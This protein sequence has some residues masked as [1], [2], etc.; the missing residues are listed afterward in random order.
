[1]RVTILARSFL[2]ALALSWVAHLPTRA[3]ETKN[4]NI[5]T[6]VQG[7]C[8]IRGVDDIRFGALDPSQAAN[9]IASGSIVLACT[10]G[11][12]FRVTI[13]QGL[14]ADSR[15]ATRRRLRSAGSYF[16]PYALKT[17]SL[18]GVGQGVRSPT[19]IVLEAV[20]AG[21]DFRDL[22]ADT[23]SDTLRVTVEY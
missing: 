17:E 22:P 4:V 11:V 2:L 3:A 18:A 6:Q 9:V 15:A 10:R 20:I 12:D 14:H 21:A 16:L 8:L 23:Y 19:R 13:D 5:A 7:R 1:M